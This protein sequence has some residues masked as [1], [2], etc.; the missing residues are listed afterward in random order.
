MCDSPSRRSSIVVDAKASMAAL[1]A[2]D[3][4]EEA[5]PDR[6]LSLHAQQLR[7]Q[8]KLLSGKAYWEGLTQTPDYVVSGLPSK[9]FYA[10][11]AERDPE[12]FEFAFKQHVIIVTPAILIA[13]AKIV[14]Y[15][16][17]QEKVAENA[18]RVH[19]IGQELYR[20]F[21]TM[22]GHIL[23][24]GNSLAGSIRK[25][26]DFVGSLESAVMPQARRFNELEVEGTQ[27]SYLLSC[28][29]R[30]NQGGCG[31]NAISRAPR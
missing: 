31:P 15:N 29:S 26:N 1:D 11:A 21:T 16:W 19:E 25:Y 22:G 8:V 14:A 27:V 13:L 3:W 17:R 5:E 24:L 4:I 23:G 12:L 2:I 9:N 20:R 10:A 7:S 6:H 28:Q 18:Q 30:L